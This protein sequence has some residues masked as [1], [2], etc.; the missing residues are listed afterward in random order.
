ML[1]DRQAMQ[2]TAKT[3]FEDRGFGFI[4]PDDGGP[5]IFVHLVA[6]SESS[7]SRTASA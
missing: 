1:K 2:G 7:I 6:A 5:D 3:F 4:S